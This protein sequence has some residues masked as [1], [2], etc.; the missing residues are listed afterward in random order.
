MYTELELEALKSSTMIIYK[1]VNLINGKVYIGQTVNT[2]NRRY[3]GKGVGVERIT[4]NYSNNGH[5]LNAIEKYGANNFKVEIL[6]QC[7]TMEELNERETYY[8]EHY[9]SNDDT[10]GYNKIGGG[11]NSYWNWKRLLWT[12]INNKDDFKRQCDKIVKLSKKLG[13]S[14]KDVIQDIH[15][16]PIFKVS[17][18]TG[19]IVMYNNILSCCYKNEDGSP[20]DFK[21]RTTGFYSLIDVLIICKQSENDTVYCS[22]LKNK[23]HSSH[24]F[25]FCKEGE[26]KDRYDTQVK[27]DMEIEIEKAN[28]KREERERKKAEKTH[29]CQLC[30]KEYKTTSRYCADCNRKAREE[31][32]NHGK[33]KKECTYCGKQH[34][35][36]HPTCSTQCSAK[37]RNIRKNSSCYEL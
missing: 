10:K 22:Q 4:D 18:R 13:I 23:K 5:L 12:Y 14:Y 15:K 7:K 34:T 19:R 30:G 17:K 32:L 31:K 16:K 28:K 33:T 2:F 37:L 11:T 27:R 29:K 35:R 21:K 6:E 20:I 9:S 26:L 8:V 3:G 1:I 24:E 25:H 36:S